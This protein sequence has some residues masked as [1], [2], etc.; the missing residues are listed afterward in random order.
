[1]IDKSYIRYLLS[2]RRKL[3]DIID[4]EIQEGA[5]RERPHYDD[6][7]QSLIYNIETT[8]IISDKDFS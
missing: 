2:L 5:L 6:I 1:M 3:N 4:A 7:K 8:N